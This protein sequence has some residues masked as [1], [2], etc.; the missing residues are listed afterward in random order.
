[1]IIL[2]I[3]SK[4]AMLWVLIRITY[5]HIAYKIT[6]HFKGFLVFDLLPHPW[7]WTWSPTHGMQANRTG[8]LW[9]KYECL[10]T[11]ETNENPYR[12]PM[13]QVRMLSYQW[14][15]KYGL[16]ENNVEILLFEDVLDFDL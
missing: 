11:L 4:K 3:S 7:V 13:V 10:E 15:S 5:G 9:A 6:P 2:P 16:L 8:Y 14:L 1:M 12:V